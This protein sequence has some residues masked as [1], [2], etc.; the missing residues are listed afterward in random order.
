LECLI[1]PEIEEFFQSVFAPDEKVF[2]SLFASTRFA[3]DSYQISGPTDYIGSGN[4]RYTNFHHIHPSLTK[5]Y[6][7]A[8]WKEV[9]N[10]SKFF[11]RKVESRR[12]EALLGRI[13]TELLNR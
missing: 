12:S 10:S 13:D 2:H 9:S 7:L 4:W 6:E 11:I 1:T 8:D 5:V 3:A